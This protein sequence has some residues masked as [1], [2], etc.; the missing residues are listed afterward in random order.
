VPERLN[1]ILNQGGNMTKNITFNQAVEE[2]ELVKMLKQNVVFSPLMSFWE[3]EDTVNVV[4]AVQTAKAQEITIAELKALIAYNIELDGKIIPEQEIMALAD[5]IQNNQT[6][7]LALPCLTRVNKKNIIKLLRINK[8]QFASTYLFKK[9]PGKA[10]VNDNVFV[11]PFLQ[12]PTLYALLK[13]LPDEQ[14][15]SIAIVENIDEI[16]SVKAMHAI[17]KK[18]KENPKI[19]P[20]AATLVM[21]EDCNLRCIYCYE[22]HQKRDKTIMSFEMAK[23]VLR[24]FDRDSKITFFGGEP[25]LHI[26]LMKQICEWGWEFRNFTFEMVTNGQIVDRE[27]FRNYAKYFDYVQLSC[28]GPESANDINRGH[29]SFGRCM[30]FMRVFYEETGRYPV[31]HPVLSK[32]SIPYLL[33]IIKWYYEKESGICAQENKY[34]GLRWLPGDASAWEE[35]DFELYAEQLTL[36]KEWYLE[37]NIRT[38][39]FSIRAFAQAEQG[40]LGIDN[41]QRPP[42]RGRDPFCSAGTNMMAVLPTGVMVPCHHEYWCEAK[43]R[44]YEQLA[45]NEDAPGINHMSEIRVEDIPECNACPQW[46]CCICPGSFYFHSKSYTKPDKNWCRAGKI[47]IETAKSYVE[48]LVQKIRDENNKVNYLAAGVDYLLTETAR[49]KGKQ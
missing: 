34:G 26:D 45:L 21:S 5:I 19:Q 6:I 3:K 10:L 41:E 29:G 17:S 24:K 1:I 44:I 37:N 40:L 49:T 23:Q 7:S 33:E 11:L 27:F 36:I 42:L 28:D 39:S 46:G 31:L 15:I 25:M 13:V 22:P 2:I 16:I 12:L 20:D 48:A 32:Y 35:K 14:K 9:I 8:Y 43:D 18:I 4:Q 30:E 38:T 47:L